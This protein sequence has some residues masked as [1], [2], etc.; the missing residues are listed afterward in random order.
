MSF[1]I[2]LQSLWQRVKITEN[3][4]LW[5][6]VS[7][8]IRGIK[9]ASVAVVTAPH[10]LKRAASLQGPSVLSPSFSLSL[11]CQSLRMLLLQIFTITRNWSWNR[12]ASNIY[13]WW[14]WRRQCNCVQWFFAVDTKVVTCSLNCHDSFS[15]AA[16]PLRQRC[17][18]CM[19]SAQVLI[20]SFNN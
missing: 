16:S 2:S 5:Q 11:N 12:R 7:A 14:F 10:H 13:G 20:V 17:T 3:H 4:A 6:M 8:T 15:A 18:R 9:A 19:K 1:V